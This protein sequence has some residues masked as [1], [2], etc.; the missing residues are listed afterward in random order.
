MLD[1]LLNTKYECNPSNHSRTSEGHTYA[2]RE[3]H[4]KNHSLVFRGA[5]NLY[6]RQNL[7]IDSVNIE[8]VSHT[9]YIHEKV[10]TVYPRHNICCFIK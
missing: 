10:K 9:Y 8:T 2:D 6:I 5:R 3:G 1:K 4:S 7:E